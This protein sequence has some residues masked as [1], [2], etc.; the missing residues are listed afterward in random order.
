M[1]T[2]GVKGPVVT[3]DEERMFDLEKRHLPLYKTFCVA[4]PRELNEKFVLSVIM[5]L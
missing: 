2:K 4:L 5:I 1:K 3:P